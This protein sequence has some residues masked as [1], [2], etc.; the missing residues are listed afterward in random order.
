MQVKIL[1][2]F[3]NRKSIILTIK[4]HQN[5]MIL[6][7][8]VAFTKSSLDIRH[9]SPSIP[10]AEGFIPNRGNRRPAFSKDQR[11]CYQC[12]CRDG[13]AS[14]VA[15]VFAAT[16]FVAHLHDHRSSCLSGEQI[17]AEASVRAREKPWEVDTCDVIDV[18][19][20]VCLDS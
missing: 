3:Y 4:S 7:H 14:C 17:A 9:L 20:W 5:T 8:F 15:D 2:T 19:V 18:E 6:Q 10:G 13:L 11:V 1:T 12:F 16:S